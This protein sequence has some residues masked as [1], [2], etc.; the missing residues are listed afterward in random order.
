MK[1]A[2]IDIAECAIRY[3]KKEQDQNYYFSELDLCYSVNGNHHIASGIVNETGYIEAYVSDDGKM[4]QEELLKEG[5]ARVAYVY[6]PNTRYVDEF[7]EFQKVAQQQGIG[8]WEIENYAQEDGS[9]PKMIF[10]DIKEEDPE[11]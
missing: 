8:I 11:D 1:N 4:V 6:S 7:N 3:D 9:H 5:L 10:K 2:I